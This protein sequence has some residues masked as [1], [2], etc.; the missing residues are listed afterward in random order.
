MLRCRVLGH[1]LRFRADGAT[2]RWECE[3]GCGEAGSKAYASETDAARYADAFNRRDS[4]D[5][6]TRP[7]ISTAPLWLVRRLRRRGR[8]D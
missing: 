1:R 7:T 6:G 5:I 2:M 4:E 3:R 8:G